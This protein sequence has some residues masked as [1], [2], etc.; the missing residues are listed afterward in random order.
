MPAVARLLAWFEANGCKGSVVAGTNGE[1]PSLSAPEKRDLIESAVKHRG[2]LEIVLGIATPSLDEAKWLCKRAHDSEAAGVLL[3]PPFYFRDATEEGIY[4]WFMRVLDESPARI[5]IYNFPQK[6]GVTISPELMSRL[7][8]HDQ[9]AGLKDSSGNQEN[10]TSFKQ[11][12]K[13]HD[14]VLF[15]GNEELLLRALD[16]GWTG[17]ISGAANVVPMW[18]SQV[19]EERDGGSLESAAAKFD[20]I[21]PCLSSI[22][23]CKQPA[24]NKALLYRLGVLP[25]PDV[26]A[27]L[28]QPGTPAVDEIANLLSTRL[29]LNFPLAAGSVSRP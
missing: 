28:E 8:A 25:R 27:P 13:K 19:M 11:C 3:M 15:V 2:T 1:G 9:F 29:G 20:L 4:E 12:L 26:R 23:A 22:R 21:L 6:T 18:L 17:T 16:Y 14:A 24:M 7:S 10:L 5:L